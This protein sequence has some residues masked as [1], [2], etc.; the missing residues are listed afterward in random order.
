MLH[1]R[2]P[3]KGHVICKHN[4]AGQDRKKTPFCTEILL[5][6]ERSEEGGGRGPTLH[7]VDLALHAL[8]HTGVER[9]KS[10]KPTRP[11]P[12]GAGLGPPRCEAAAMFLQ[13]T[14]VREA[15]R[16][17][18]S[19]ERVHLDKGSSRNLGNSEKFIKKQTNNP[20]PFAWSRGPGLHSEPCVLASGRPLV[21]G[22]Q[23]RR[24]AGSSGVGTAQATWPPAVG[25]SC[26]LAE[27]PALGG[28]PEDASRRCGSCSVAACLAG[29]VPGRSAGFSETESGR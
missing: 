27:G 20:T 6:S 26:L 9:F 17:P 10:G 13:D 8:L 5:E 3:S 16:V 15:A 7:S 14:T 29:S 22:S 12:R 19:P 21:A 25:S 24:P 18:L 23:S 1:G 11:H 4:A 28:R 2:L